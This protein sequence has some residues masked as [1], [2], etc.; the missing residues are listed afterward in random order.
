M[1]FG[2]KHT[3]IRFIRDGSCARTK[4]ERVSPVE[5]HIHNT[6]EMRTPK[7]KT[8]NNVQQ[9]RGTVAAVKDFFVNKR[10]RFRSEVLSL[11]YIL[12][13]SKCDILSDLQV[14]SL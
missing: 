10:N 8:R 5:V 3:E 12:F 9:G 4:N 1:E 7:L 13:V 2:V 14:V 11:L 6:S